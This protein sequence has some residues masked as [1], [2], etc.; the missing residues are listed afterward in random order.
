MDRRA[1]LIMRAGLHLSAGP[2]RRGK[3]KHGCH[4][5]TQPLVTTNCQLTEVYL[6][7]CLGRSSQVCQRWG[8]TCISWS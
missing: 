8:G 5:Y 1:V 2:G 7:R 6:S 4:G 3:V